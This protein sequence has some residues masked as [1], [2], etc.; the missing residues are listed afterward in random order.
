MGVTKTKPNSC[1]PV[2]VTA[3]GLQKISTD[4]Q[5]E[6][7]WIEFIITLLRDATLGKGRKLDFIQGQGVFY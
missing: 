7:F 5:I 4:R 6:Y 1:H 2:C 3:P